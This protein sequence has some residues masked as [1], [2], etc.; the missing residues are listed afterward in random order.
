MIHAAD[1]PKNYSY[2]DSKSLGITF[3]ITLHTYL[4]LYTDH[5]FENLSSAHDFLQNLCTW[6]KF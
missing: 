5:D 6:L 2:H 3:T 4:L 1:I